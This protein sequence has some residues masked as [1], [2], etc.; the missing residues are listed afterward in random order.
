MPT[1]WGQDIARIPEVAERGI[2]IQ[3]LRDFHVFVQRLCKTRMLKKSAGLSISFSEVNMYHLAE[4]VIKPVISWVEMERGT[5]R[6]CSWVEFVAD[7][8]V[9]RQPDFMF[10]HGWSGRF[11]DFMAAVER[12]RVKRSLAGS[13]I[14]WICT[15]ANSQFGEDFGQG[16]RESPFF[17][18]VSSLKEAMVLMVDRDAS[19]LQRI[20]CGFELYVGLQQGTALEIYTSAGRVGVDV[21]TGPL[22]EALEAFDVTT[23]EASQDTDRRQIL[24]YLSCGEAHERDGLLLDEANNFQLLHGWQ[25][26]LDGVDTLPSF[27]RR[28]NGCAE[29]A[30]EARLIDKYQSKF[31]RFNI[32]VKRQVLAAAQ[33]NPDD[34]A[35]Q[36]SEQHASPQGI[37]LGEMRSCVKKLRRIVEAHEGEKPWEDMTVGDVH[38]VW[39]PKVTPKGM[40]YA[41]SCCKGL[42]TA[43]YVIDETYD[44]RM[45]ECLTA[46]EWFAEA[47]QLP[48]SSVFYFYPFCCVDQVYVDVDEHLRLT[49]ERIE[50]SEGMLSLLPRE[51]AKIVRANRMNLLNLCFTNARSIYFGCS[52]GVLACS[53]P[54]V[55][56]SWEFGSFDPLIARELLAADWRLAASADKKVEEHIHSQVK[57]TRG[58]MASFQA[59]L[60][61]VAAGPVLRQAVCCNSARHMQ[62]VVQLCGSRGFSITSPVLRGPLGETA[63]HI[64]AANGN[65]N[66]IRV[67]LAEKADA[68]AEDHIRETPLHYAAMAGN[69]RAV[70]VLLQAGA[71]PLAESFFAEDPLEVAEQNPAAFLVGLEG[72]HK[73]QEL[74]RAWKRAGDVDDD[75]KAIEPTISWREEDGS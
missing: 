29:Y 43:Q 9:E 67:L 49:R 8:Q 53:S 63:L 60:A 30:H 46:I 56:G 57:G 1:P 39:L 26:Q 12:L 17:K 31:E 71:S 55:G 73:V 59:R 28:A 15:F 68:Q 62:E 20:W 35:A 66:F 4:L 64:A 23:M 32:R 24:N 44:S 47:M 36:G 18:A 21:N 11:M 58:G 54:F 22:V 3:Q 37:T 13:T 48:D 72:P 5:N 6:R 10:S 27:K 38:T 50:H 16:L 40:S 33:A 65:L 34:G 61:R 75:D 45:H 7:A 70:T 74:L 51:R 69:A 41:E 14:I 2:S 19:S 42:R 25:K 52:S